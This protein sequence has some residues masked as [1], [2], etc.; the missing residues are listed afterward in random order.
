MMPAVSDEPGEN[1]M[2]FRDHNGQMSFESFFDLCAEL[3]RR[4]VQYEIKSVRGGALMV[5]V[6]VPG[7]RWEVEIFEDGTIE[8]ERFVSQ[9]VEADPSAQTRLLA[10]FDGASDPQ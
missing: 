4:H 6:A 5:Q 7:E 3:D 10:F 8:V 9:G 2:S 1:Q